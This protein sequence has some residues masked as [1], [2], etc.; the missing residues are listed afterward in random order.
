[1]GFNN[2]RKEFYLAG[3]VLGSIVVEK[4]L[5]VMVQNNLKVEA[6]FNRAANAANRMLGMIKRN[7]DCRSR[8]VVVPLY[9]ALVRPHLNYCVQAWKPHLRKDVDKLEKI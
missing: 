4:D 5:G 6:Q 1:M 2:R 7:F 8:E 9:K 3:K